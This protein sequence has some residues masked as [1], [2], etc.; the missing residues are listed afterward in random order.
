VK[1]T[2]SKA[3]ATP[4]AGEATFRRWLRGRAE[5]AAEQGRP[6]TKSRCIR[7]SSTDV[8]QWRASAITSFAAAEREKDPDVVEALGH[9]MDLVARDQ[10]GEDKRAELGDAVF[11]VR[12]CH[13]PGGVGS[14]Q[15]GVILPVG[16]TLFVYLLASAR[17]D[18]LEAASDDRRGN[19]ATEILSTTVRE[20]FAVGRRHDP[21]YRPQ[22]HAREHERIVRDENHGANLKKTLISCCAVAFTPNRVD[23][24][25][26]AESQSFS[27]GTLI[28]AQAVAGLVR[29]MN[30]AEIVLQSTG[31]YYTSVG[32]V[33]FTHEA[34]STPLIDM[35]TGAAYTSIDKH[36]L[37]VVAD[38]DEA[39]RTLRAIVDVLLKDR[40]NNH[41]LIEQLPDWSAAAALP[42]VA[43]LPSRLPADLKRGITLASKPVSSRVQSLKSIVSRRWIE[44]WRTGFITVYV[45]VK[46][47]VDLD[48]GEDAQLV[49][50]GSRLLYRCRVAVPLPD[51]G[52]GISEDEWDELLRR[53]YPGRR[54]TP[55]DDCHPLAGVGWDDVGA[56]REGRLATRSRYLVQS[57]RLSSA[58][59]L[60]GGRLGWHEDPSVRHEATVTSHRLH[61][62]VAEAGRVALV[63]LELPLPTLVLRRPGIAAEA[64]SDALRERDAARLAAEVEEAENEL[65]GAESWRNRA[66]GAAERL[67]SQPGA[68]AQVGAQ[69]DLDRA[70]KAVVRAEESLAAAEAALRSFEAGAAACTGAPR[71]DEDVEL[72]T[73]T[74]EFVVAALEK[75]RG[76]APL[77]LQ[78]ACATL[79]Q[80]WHFEVVRQHG[81]RDVVRWRC[82]LVLD[83][84]GEGETVAMPL[85]GEV[86]SSSNC[87]GAAAATTVEDWAW[88]FFY[89][90]QSLEEVGLAAGI[91]GSG[92][93]NSYL[94]KRLCEWLEPAV[95]DAT[96]RNAAVTCPV[97]AVRRVL[98]AMVTADL[99]SVRTLNAAFVAHI[100]N[101]YGTPAWKPSWSWCRDTHE[102]GRAVAARLAGRPAEGGAVHELLADLQISRDALL[103]TARE[104]GATT[105]GQG[106][107]ATPAR[108]VAY[109]CKTFRRGA[110]TVAPEQRRLLLRPCP[111]A[112]CPARLAGGQGYATVVLNVPETEQWH[113][114]LCPKC[115]RA[116]HPDAVDGRF[117][118]D[119]VRPWCGR[120]GSRSTSGRARSQTVWTYLDPNLVDPG[121]APRL[122]LTGAG[123]RPAPA[124][125]PPSSRARQ[126]KTGLQGRRVLS[127]GLSRAEQASFQ[128]R[129]VAL[130]GTVG[131]RV[132]ASLACVVV[133][134]GS[135]RAWE[136]ADRAARLGVPVVTLAEFGAWS[137]PVAEGVAR[138][139]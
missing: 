66:E 87:S 47:D 34:T 136:K 111:H 11:V 30:R 9:G 42:E 44:G 37:A 103:S 65:V 51:G 17:A 78:A 88:R 81:A 60:S 4:G 80:D 63:S 93:K 130:G 91:D 1:R 59:S 21:A 24:L 57:R 99:D 13:A 40:V 105:T 121:P 53:R 7:T 128:A 19:A 70:R 39:R 26:P 16:C 61:R 108:A 76:V 33:P 55:T 68:E 120:Y 56:D 52:W 97:P 98:W 20:M 43:A 94:Y 113:G 35:R 107:R 14:R 41:G 118:A 96:L 71:G 86:M 124:P 134:A 95:P 74:A 27:F 31:G 77:W 131:H 112:D 84:T 106:E 85:T 79:F 83:S 5:L 23:L 58:R 115:R 82:L 69:R 117:T 22:V 123:P 62:S 67:R 137:P 38:V 28:S 119:F 139:A 8:N 12:M 54:G 72:I 127:L 100:R 102:V 133:P 6:I 15:L 109:F 75:C 116:P 50:K 64:E 90:G 2:R 48:L 101:I 46:S 138:P 73:G 114:V 3:K 45:P 18:D 132:K 126:A 129:T 122:P 92:K 32:Q 135:A 89:L 10:S 125:R 29:G 25:K 104:N 110:P 49:Q 36:R